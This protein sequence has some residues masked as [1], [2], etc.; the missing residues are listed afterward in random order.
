MDERE[1]WAGA[2]PCKRATRERHERKREEEDERAARVVLLASLACRGRAMSFHFTPSPT[3]LAILDVS[4]RGSD[5][6]LRR[7]CPRQCKGCQEPQCAMPWHESPLPPI[8]QLLL[9]LASPASTN[10]S[11]EPHRDSSSLLSSSELLLPSYRT[12]ISKQS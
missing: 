6:T 4:G 7:L 10:S 12:L 5:T 1:T 8:K 9:L 3:A 2:W 11:P